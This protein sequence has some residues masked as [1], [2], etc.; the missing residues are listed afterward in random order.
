MPKRF[1]AGSASNRIKAIRTEKGLTQEEL[2]TKAGISRSTLHTYESAGF[3]GRM[4]TTVQKSIAD[5][6]EKAPEEVFSMSS[7]THLDRRQM[8]SGAGVGLLALSTFPFSTSFPMNAH[9][10]AFKQLNT[11]QIHEIGDSNFATW[12]LFDSAQSEL[13]VEYVKAVTNG[14]IVMLSQLLQLS[15][16]PN[17]KAKVQNLLADMYILLGRISIEQQNY[18]IANQ[19]LEQAEA[20]ALETRTP[21]LIAAMRQRYSFLYIEQERYF[22]AVGQAN[23]ALDEIKGASHPL[24]AEARY[25]AAEALARTGEMRAALKLHHET[26]QTTSRQ[27]PEFW[28]GKLRNMKTNALICEILIFLSGN[29]N[30]EA[31]QTTE[32]TMKQVLCDEPDNLRWLSR[33]ESLHATALWQF[34][35]VDASMDYAQRALI[36]ARQVGSLR[37]ETHIEKLFQK[38]IASPY[39]KQPEV[40]SLGVALAQE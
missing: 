3:K 4:P 35:A 36:H 16:I 8:F 17:Q 38:A 11:E 13:Q 31:M 39:R 14:K 32:A 29:K 9:T 22:Q 1:S 30:D 5:V 34:G 19:A 23:R 28:Y 21:D 37:N 26:Q 25:M 10:Q 33:V 18:S 20:I 15:L 7:Q 12:S 2:A 40:K 27:E 6:L 24:W